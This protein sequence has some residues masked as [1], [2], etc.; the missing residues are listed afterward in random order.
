MRKTPYFA[1]CAA[2]LVWQQAPAADP[3]VFINQITTSATVEND[4]RTA[5]PGAVLTRVNQ[6]SDGGV[7]VDAYAQLDDN[8]TAFQSYSGFNAVRVQAALANGYPQ[9]IFRAHTSYDISVTTGTDSQAL[10]LDYLVFPGVVGLPRFAAA[11]SRARISYS[12]DTAGPISNPTTGIQAEVLLERVLQGRNVVTQS[13]VDPIF[14]AAGVQTSGA[15]DVEGFLVDTIETQPFFDTVYLGFYSPVSLVEV[16]YQMEALIE[17]P[18]YE[19]AAIARIGDPFVLRADIQA[20]I[21]RYFPGSDV[22]FRIRAVKLIPEPTAGWFGVVGLACLAFRL[23]QR[24][25]VSRRTE[26]DVV[27]RYRT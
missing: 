4:E 12:V 8:N 19:T 26:K 7:S 6:D 20:Q 27:L 1:L 24:R 10:F 5:Q 21:D 11:G 16:R 15:T 14:T 22:P 9:N 17:I 2:C 23:R 18:G 3:D 25:D 13:T